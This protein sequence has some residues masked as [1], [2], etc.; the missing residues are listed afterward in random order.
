M[1]TFKP[2][3]TLFDDMPPERADRLRE[4]AQQMAA[5]IRLAEVRKRHKATQQFMAERMQVSQ[6][7]ISQIESQGDMQLSTLLRYVHALGGKVS[8]Q[9]EIDGEQTVLVQG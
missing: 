4:R 6:S 7:S 3:A 5:A 2:L 9:I 1:S 8:I